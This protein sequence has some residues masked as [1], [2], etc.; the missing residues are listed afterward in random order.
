MIKILDVTDGTLLT[1]KQFWTRGSV[2]PINYEVLLCNEFYVTD[3]SLAKDEYFTLV[4]FT[5][6]HNPDFI[7][8]L[9]QIIPPLKTSEFSDVSKF[10]SIDEEFNNS[11]EALFNKNPK[12][13]YDFVVEIARTT[14]KQLYYRIIDSIFWFVTK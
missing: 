1:L 6:D 11:F 13:K 10:E 3:D 9:W 14:K 12:R 2:D 5:K 4:L 7:F 8:D